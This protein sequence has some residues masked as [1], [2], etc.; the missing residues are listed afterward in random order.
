[1]VL[2]SNVTVN[3]IGWKSKRMFRHYEIVHT[4]CELLDFPE[5]TYDNCITIYIYY[6]MQV[7]LVLYIWGLL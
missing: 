4:V 6:H 1:M 5:Q 2:F 3:R 7:C